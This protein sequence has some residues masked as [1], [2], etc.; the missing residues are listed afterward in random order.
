MKLIDFIVC[1]DIRREIGNKH[2]L[3]GVYDE[4][5]EFSVGKSGFKQWPKAMK[6]GFFIRVNFDD[7]VP[8]EFSF[9][10]LFLTEKKELGKGK[11]IINPT[12]SKRL[13]IVIVHNAFVFPNEGKIEFELVFYK[14]GKIIQEITPDCKLIIKESLA[15][16]SL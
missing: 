4:T 16:S 2:T 9:N 7:E 8:D 11:V 12:A 5:V 1:D 13:N 14:N 15:S 3:V 10:M 6:L